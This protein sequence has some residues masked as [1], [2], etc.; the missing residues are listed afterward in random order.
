MA[1]NSV[2]K[3]GTAEAKAP[4]VAEGDWFDAS[5]MEMRRQMD[6][7]FDSFAGGWHLP[8]I[9]APFAAPFAAPPFTAPH[10]G[11]GTVSLRFDV[12]ESDDALEVSAELPGMDEKDIEVSLENGLLTVKGEKKAESE[13]TEKDY[14]VAERR[15]GSFR[16]SFRLPD[17]VDEDKIQAKFDKG[18]LR[19]ILPKVA[20]A[21]HKAR[22][23]S[24]S[25]P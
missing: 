19:V 11:G 5:F 2:S 3:T 4:A 16:R 7:L 1:K 17:T 22:K 18:V 24:I 25:K 15:Y 21:G 9:A 12:S 6:R 8:S 14:Y 10:L 20:E 23:I 13:R